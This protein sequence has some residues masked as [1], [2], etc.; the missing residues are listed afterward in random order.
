MHAKPDS[1]TVGAII[2]LVK[3]QM[4]KAN[5]EYQRGAVWKPSQKKKLIDSVMRGYTL[6]LIYLHHIKTEV[7]GMKREDLEIIDGQQRINSLFE[8]AEGAFKLFD[9]VADEREARF[10]AFIKEQPCPWAGR[11]FHGL[12][13]AEKSRF[14]ETTLHVAKITTG[15]PN[16]VRDLFVRLQ[17]GSPLSHQETR[18]AWPGQFTEFVL[19]LGGKP[20]LPRYPGHDFFT[21]TLRMKPGA[22]RGKTRQLAAQIAMLFLSRRHSSAGGFRDTNAASLNDYY[23]EQLGFDQTS[24]DAKRLVDILD[25]LTRLID[26]KKHAKLLGHDAIHLVLLADALWDDYAPTWQEKLPPALDGFK[27]KALEA[28]RNDWTDEFWSKYGQWTRVS[29]D[30]GTF[31]GMRHTFY[32]EK[33]FALM[34]PLKLKDSKRTFG[35]L[36]REILFYRQNKRCLVCDGQ[37][38]WGEGEVHHVE[39]HSQGGATS[40]ENGA[41]VHKVCHPKGKEATAAFAQKF[42]AMKEA[43]ASII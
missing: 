43:P 35:E 22:D 41:L 3:A 17:S 8:F 26:P 32:M 12:S 27:A 21:R 1:M 36:D 18:D 38:S 39:E 42:A 13:D 31:I 19:R 24:S 30:K 15:E 23:Y 29:A 2:Q 10:P 20:E 14:L 25:T 40:L 16:E 37:I 28:K 9:P 7:E 11:D 6:P 4:L 33:M 34:E 5:P